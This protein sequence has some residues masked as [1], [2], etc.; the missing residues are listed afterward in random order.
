VPGSGPAEL[1]GWWRRFGDYVLY[2]LIVDVP[3]LIVSTLFGLTQPHN[4][5]PGTTCGRR[6]LAW[7]TEL[8]L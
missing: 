7:L 2:V 6:Q 5:V 1:A 8:M 4:F 3:V